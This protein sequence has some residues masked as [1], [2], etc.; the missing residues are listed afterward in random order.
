MHQI[1]Q[2]VQ[3]PECAD[4]HRRMTDAHQGEHQSRR[5]ERDAIE[6]FRRAHG[7]LTG[8]Q[9]EQRVQAGQDEQAHGVQPALPADGS[10]HDDGE[11]TGRGTQEG[12]EHDSL[13]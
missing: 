3:Q 11:D 4:E 6:H 13:P 10:R 9:R 7:R 1:V 5:Q 2:P 12:F 8:S